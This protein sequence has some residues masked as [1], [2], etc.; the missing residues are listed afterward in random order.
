MIYLEHLAQYQA[1]SKYLLI[2]YYIK[3][4]KYL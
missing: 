4:A 1:H 2:I 3:D